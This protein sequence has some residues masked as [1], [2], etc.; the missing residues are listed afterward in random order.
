LHAT[1]FWFR[2]ELRVHALFGIPAANTNIIETLD[3]WFLESERFD[4]V[5]V[6]GRIAA[7]SL[8]AIH[9]HLADPWARAA[10]A[11]K[12]VGRLNAEDARRLVG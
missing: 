12:E 2:L 5:G 7:M 4:R 1:V 9:H 6:R 3:Y 10:V 11:L 8:A